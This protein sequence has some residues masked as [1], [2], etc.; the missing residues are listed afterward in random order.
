MYACS[1]NIT[2]GADQCSDSRPNS[3]TSKTNLTWKIRRLLKV[4]ASTGIR[5]TRRTKP[6]HDLNPQTE[7]NLATFRVRMPIVRLCGCKIHCTRLSSGTHLYTV[8]R[9][10]QMGTDYNADT[11]TSCPQNTCWLSSKQFTATSNCRYAMRSANILL[12][13]LPSAHGLL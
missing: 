8:T 5:L 1:H 10:E 6:D 4:Q 12:V 13:K 3:S 9:Y 7:N 2:R 11:Y